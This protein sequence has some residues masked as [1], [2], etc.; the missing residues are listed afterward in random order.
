MALFFLICNIESLICASVDSEQIPFNECQAGMYS[1]KIGRG[2]DR[3]VHSEN[4]GV[5]SKDTTTRLLLKYFIVCYA[6]ILSLD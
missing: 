4:E 2:I 3:N 1:A 5:F 6:L